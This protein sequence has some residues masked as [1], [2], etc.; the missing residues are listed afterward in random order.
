V[1]QFSLNY[2]TIALA[3]E[4]STMRIYSPISRISSLVVIFFFLSLA[5]LPAQIS[6]APLEQ[7]KSPL[8]DQ[9]WV[10]LGGPLGGLG[11]D[12]RM[13]P[14]NPDIMFV[15]DAWAG[16]HKSTDGGRTW[17][18]LND[19]ID[20]RT[21]PSGDAIPVFC[22][23]I[24]PNNYDIIWIGL[25]NLGAVY[26]SGD[27]GQTWRK[28]ISGIVEGEG[29]TIRGITV[30]PGNSD[31]VYV[32]GE[33]SSWRWAGQEMWGREF[34]RVR[35][36]VYK[37]TDGGAKWKAVWRGD[38]LARY[39]WIDP[40][41]HNIVYVSTGIFDRESA[42]SD[43]NTNTAGGEGVIKSLD[44]GETWTN[45]NNGL[46]NLYVGSLFM[47]PQDSNILLAATG[48]NTYRNGGGVYLTT[49]GGASWKHVT[50]EH[51][52]SVEFSLAN[53]QI[54]YAA[55]DGQFYR[56]E[57]GG[58]TWK[59]LPGWGPPGIRPGFPIDFQVDPR[60]P[61]R[62]FVNNYGGGN[63]LS[64]DGGNT[65]VTAST[66]YTGADLRDVFVDPGNPAFV[67]ANGRSGPFLSRDGGVTW[68][69]INPVEVR[70]IAEGARV[71][72][73]PSNAQHILL[74]SAH[75]GWTYE[76]L[77][78]GNGWGLVTN[79]EKE[80]D[81]LSI[82]DTNKKFQ[83]FQAITF[84]P[85]DPRIVYGGFGIWRCATNADQD[86]CSAKTIV[87]LLLSK[88]GGRNWL[89]LE[90]T[91][92]DGLTISEIVVHPTNPNIAWVATVGGGVF[93]TED[94]G[95]TWISVNRGLGSYKIM[96]L[97]IDPVNPSI[98]Y[99]GTENR[100]VFKSEDSGESWKA[101]S[102]GVDSNEPIHA[103]VVDPAHPQVVYAG[104]Y[105]SGVFISEDGGLHWRLINNGLRTRAVTS[106]T[107]SKDGETLYAGTTGEGVF[108]LSI[109]DQTY[110]I[111]LVPTPAPTP[112]V[113]LPTA[114]PTSEATET[115]NDVS[116]PLPSSTPETSSKPPCIGAVI[117][118]LGLV[119]FAQWRRKSRR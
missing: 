86:M 18:T 101:M 39:I 51:V 67:L 48:S 9:S 2:A 73:D 118:P 57:D 6:A 71:T 66:G 1:Y 93:H 45:I 87:S 115:F 34:D 11:Y 19:G 5:I 47:H 41:D 52:T 24:D 23:T 76:S 84:A 102:A 16:V 62:I 55:G 37:S 78:G 22:L 3:E 80:L 42:N 27:G 33:I 88:N 10:R 26:R 97:A 20:A 81:S 105:R 38:N 69:G 70:A 7:E 68:E 64:E 111:S 79:Y 28:R 31:I 65:W 72:L 15:T 77:N 110:F 60:D 14:D 8:A 104:S 50:G 89:R 113:V 4:N 40:N 35:G 100:G 13:R 99:A 36:V 63:F 53:P 29:L 98:L 46:E 30:E 82:P 59:S 25:Q 94:L 74:S 108:R 43:P 44:G 91:P 114:T 119:F 12:I 96:D 107:I 117:V 58:K 106:L 17:F 21:G 109:H 112:T 83:G 90:G 56:S 61:Y 75:W 85:S 32:A 92:L 54:A 49:D 95:Q 103:L 116:T